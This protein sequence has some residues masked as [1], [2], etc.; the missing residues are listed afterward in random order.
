MLKKCQIITMFITS[1]LLVFALLAQ[2]NLLDQSVISFI[3]GDDEK[4]FVLSKSQNMNKQKN[5]L[6]LHRNRIL[7]NKDSNINLNEIRSAFDTINY[8][9]FNESFV[10]TNDK[11]Y[12]L[13]IFYSLMFDLNR[14]QILYRTFS[15]KHNNV[16]PFLNPYTYGKDYSKKY[17]EENKSWGNYFYYFNKD[18]RNFEQNLNI[19]ERENPNNEIIV[20]LKKEIETLKINDSSFYSSVS[21][22]INNNEFVEPYI[23]RDLINEVNLENNNDK[24]RSITP[25]A[26]LF[27]LNILKNYKKTKG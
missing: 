10:Y 24:D 20:K 25:M 2:F 19:L 5:V 11:E 6:I 21:K 27:N 8:Q 3:V 16:N 22:S 17:I 15:A 26:Y 4:R 23:I 12:S 14:N 9:G 1:F 13:V 7:K 18:L